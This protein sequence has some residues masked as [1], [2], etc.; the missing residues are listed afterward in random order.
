MVQER[1]KWDE[2]KKNSMRRP[3]IARMMQPKAKMEVSRVFNHCQ[4]AEMES[5][6]SI[7]IMDSMMTPPEW[8]L[9]ATDRSHSKIRRRRILSDL[10]D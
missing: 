1:Q 2:I 4:R 3:K 10:I 6:K 9:R 5:K 7:C 8:I